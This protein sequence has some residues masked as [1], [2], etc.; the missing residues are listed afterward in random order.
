MDI[1]YIIANRHLSQPVLVYEKVTS[2]TVVNRNFEKNLPPVSSNDAIM[3][4]KISTGKK[5]LEL[6]NMHI[7]VNPSY[8]CTTWKK[9]FFEDNN[10]SGCSLS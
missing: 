9:L 1:S 4:F 7:V 2:G 5:T 3:S 8:P 10:H 6:R